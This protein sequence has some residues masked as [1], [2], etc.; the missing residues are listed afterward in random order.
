MWIYRYCDVEDDCA[1]CA[2]WAEIDA[3]D[4]FLDGLTALF[5]KEAY[6]GD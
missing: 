4:A 5:E 3:R 6:R 2:A 1:M